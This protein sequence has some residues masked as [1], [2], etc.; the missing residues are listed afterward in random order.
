M[1]VQITP[2]GI[3]SI[4]WKFY[5]IWTVLNFS[6]VPI[7]YLFYPET[8]GRRLEDID[9]LFREN[10]SIWIFKDKDATSTRRPQKYRDIEDGEI[11]NARR[12]E[13]DDAAPGTGLFEHRDN[14]NDGSDESSLD[15]KRG[16]EEVPQKK[17]KKFGVF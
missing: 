9:A 7:T 14:I 17:K 3:E 10:H 5:I 4:H 15:A 2:I 6:F 1:V 16:V 11:Q 13:K 12:A 8:S